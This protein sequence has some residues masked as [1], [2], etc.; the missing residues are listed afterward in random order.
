MCHHNKPPKRYTTSR[1]P[2]IA[3]ANWRVTAEEHLILFLWGAI[4][5]IGYGASGISFRHGILWLPL[6]LF[7][8]VATILI[9]RRMT[10]GQEQATLLSRHI[11][12]TWGVM[13]LL[14]SAIIAVL[15]PM[16]PIQIMS[17]PGILVGASYMLMGV[18]AWK[19]Y[20]VLGFTIFV[21]TLVGLYVLNWYRE[22]GS[23]E[24]FGY[25]PFWMAAVMGFGLILGGLWLRKA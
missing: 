6:S 10:R 15:R 23:P 9:A 5:V 4:S 8:S 25:F 22:L 16:M 13:L 2:K 21:L 7:G 17:F 19:R 11:A 20:A 12:L 24:S 18:W 14:S 1:L 3:A